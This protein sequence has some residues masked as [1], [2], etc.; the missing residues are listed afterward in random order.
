MYPLGDPSSETGI[1]TTTTATTTAITA[2]ATAGATDGS[3]VAGA[4]AGGTG[5]ILPLDALPALPPHTLK[6]QF[7]PAASALTIGAPEVTHPLITHPHTPSHL[8]L[9]IG[10]PE[11]TPTVSL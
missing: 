4:A 9:T 10:A 3:G 8:A 7:R 5:G 1:A 2:A 6:V 11:V